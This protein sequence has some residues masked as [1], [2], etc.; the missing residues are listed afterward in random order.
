MKLSLANK[1]RA[2]YLEAIYNLLEEHGEDVGYIESNKLNLPVVED[3]EEGIM[4]VTVS[5]L[6]S[7]EDDYVAA[8]EQYSDK[9]RERAERK[10][11]A[12]AKK[13]EKEDK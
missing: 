4:V 12:D 13:K 9:L 7:G 2:R 8:R 6:K 3:G 5:I 11:K 1:C 10:A